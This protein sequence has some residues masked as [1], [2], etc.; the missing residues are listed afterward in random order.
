[1]S[2]L[3]DSTFMQQA[4]PEAI[5]KQIAEGADVNARD[6]DGLSPLHLVAIN[7]NLAEIKGAIEAVV[8]ALV[9]AGAR[10]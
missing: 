4:T 9:R 1:M 8:E 10:L 5:K 3:L 7:K 6:D 2:L